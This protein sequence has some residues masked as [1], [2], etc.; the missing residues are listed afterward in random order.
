MFCSNVEF[1][2]LFLWHKIFLNSSNFA[3]SFKSF[4]NDR[5]WAEDYERQT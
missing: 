3:L 2:N 1:T 4:S 5:K